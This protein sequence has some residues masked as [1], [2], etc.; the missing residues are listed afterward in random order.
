MESFWY[1]SQTRKNKIVVI[2]DNVVTFV[3]VNQLI[4]AVFGWDNCLPVGPLVQ[5]VAAFGVAGLIDLDSDRILC[6]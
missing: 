4:T 5:G 1:S 3:V 6:S 2:D